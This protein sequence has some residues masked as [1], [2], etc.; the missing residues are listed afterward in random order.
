MLAVCDRIQN[1]V[2]VLIFDDESVISVPCD[3]LNCLAGVTVGERDVLDV[4]WDGDTLTGARLDIEE[5]KKR[6]DS[7]AARL[8]RLAGR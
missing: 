8:R 1:G 4:S 6:L 7:A 2:A 5:K 3:A